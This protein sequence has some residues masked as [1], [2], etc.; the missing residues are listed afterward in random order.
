MHP[1]HPKHRRYNWSDAHAPQVPSLD[2]FAMANPL[3]SQVWQRILP[4]QNNRFNIQEASYDHRS[5][6]PVTAAPN[7]KDTFNHLHRKQTH[8]STSLAG[9]LCSGWYIYITTYYILYT[10]LIL[11]IIYVYI[12]IY[13]S[14]IPLLSIYA[15]CH[16]ACGSG[17]Y[18]GWHLSIVGILLHHDLRFAGNGDFARPRNWKMWKYE[19]GKGA[20]NQSMIWYDLISVDVMSLLCSCW[21]NKQH[22][23]EPKHDLLDR[24]WALEFRPSCFVLLIL[25]TILREPRTQHGHA[26]EP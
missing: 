8:D 13:V 25:Y 11:P 19:E 4:C 1:R 21:H 14:C 12:Y 22:E 23:I 15:T 2:L 3:L 10:C 26:L 6:P 18:C 17:R 24:C 9:S 16:M 5:S 20:L 7:K